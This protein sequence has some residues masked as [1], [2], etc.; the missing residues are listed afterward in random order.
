MHSLQLP[1]TSAATTG[2]EAIS[3]I[4]TDMERIVQTLQWVF[5][6]LPNILQVAVGLYLLQN[7]LGTVFIA[8]LVIAICELQT[9]TVTRPL[10]VLVIET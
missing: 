10:V 3:L 8:P 5:N 2:P 9:V 1:A 4:S 7:R 6:I